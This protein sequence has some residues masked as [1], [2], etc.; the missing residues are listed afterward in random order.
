MGG[1]G[2]SRREL[3]P[4]R[5]EPAA[6]AIAQLAALARLA[7]ARLHATPR[8]DYDYNGN[9]IRH[10]HPYLSPACPG[11]V[12]PKR[13]TASHT[14][15]VVGREKRFTGINVILGGRWGGEGG[16]GG[17][18]RRNVEIIKFC[19]GGIRSG[20]SELIL[21]RRFLRADLMRAADV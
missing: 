14:A 9:A 20:S 17:A 4:Y 2:G 5:G 10:A 21:A 8:R 1:E 3:F 7:A 12:A 11:V 19:R 16:G 13:R 18:E 6:A 15:P